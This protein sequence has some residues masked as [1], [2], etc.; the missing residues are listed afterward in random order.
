MQVLGMLVIH[1]GMIVPME[2]FD[3]VEMVILH[4]DAFQMILI[5][6]QIDMEAGCFVG[7]QT[8][9]QTMIVALHMELVQQV[10]H[11]ISLQ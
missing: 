8:L 9:F 6:V 5:K 10:H 4:I 2:L 1:I 7:V 3:I 11:N